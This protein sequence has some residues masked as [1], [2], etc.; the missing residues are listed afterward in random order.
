M[1]IHKY[2][3]LSVIKYLKK[4]H[5]SSKEIFVEYKR[6]KELFEDEKARVF[7]YFKNVLYN[8]LNKFLSKKLNKKFIKTKIIKNLIISPKTSYT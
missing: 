2:N 5:K 6:Q 4:H 3:F 8:Y 7:W 1:L